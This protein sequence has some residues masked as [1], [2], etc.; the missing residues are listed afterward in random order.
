MGEGQ[1]LD[2]LDLRLGPGRR[3]SKEALVLVLVF[4]NGCRRQGKH[5]QGKAR[6]GGS[7]DTLWRSDRM[8]MAQCLGCPWVADDEDEERG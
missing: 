2:G 3:S 1:D 4:G 6:E 5:G 8:Q 7:L